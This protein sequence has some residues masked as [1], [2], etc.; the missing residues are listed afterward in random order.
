[1]PQLDQTDTYLSQIFWLI[2]SFGL[3]YLMMRY[4][5]IPRLRNIL[6]A[7]ANQIASDLERASTARQDAVEVLAAYERIMSGA[8]HKSDALVREAFEQHALQVKNESDKLQAELDEKFA[9]VE[10]RVK[11][12]RDAALADLERSVQPLIDEVLDKSSDGLVRSS[13]TRVVAEIRD[14]VQKQQAQ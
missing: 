9:G 5:L 2:T 3:L 8:R 10:A 4:V 7:R 14:H 6:D 1:M 12:A 11:Q 13:K